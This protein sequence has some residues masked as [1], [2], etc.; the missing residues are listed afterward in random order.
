MKP[1]SATPIPGAAATAEDTT[2]I[3]IDRER[4]IVDV[5]GTLLTDL[6]V[7]TLKKGMSLAR[8]LIKVGMPDANQALRTTVLNGKT[9]SRELVLTPSDKWISVHIEPVAKNGRISG[10]Q[11]QVSDISAWRSNIDRRQLQEKMANLSL[12]A[13]QLA[14]RLKTPLATILNQ[15]GFLLLD[16]AKSEEGR[17]LRA[18]LQA[19][20]EQV[21]ALSV[22][23]N[24]L[25]AFAGDRGG[26]T[27][28]VRI[29]LVMEKAVDLIRMMYGHAAIR[30][31]MHWPED[32]PPVLGDEIAL[33]QCFLHLLRNSLEAMTKSGR[34]TIEGRLQ[35]ANRHYLDIIIQD[36]GEG[37]AAAD[38]NRVF[39]PFFK[40]KLGDHL[41]LGLCIAY[42]IVTNLKGYMRLD[43]KPQKGTVVTVSLPVARSIIQ[44]G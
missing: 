18:E 12:L 19:I 34:L 9:L 38:L 31:Q 28:L 27:K 25:D 10:A 32:L 22:I 6:G 43:S 3:V 37:I 40:K 13:N 4:R 17:R 26:S 44:K 36:N 33:E 42:S 29:P 24:A 21:Y 35:A 14:N 7:T 39:E 23:T 30:Y 5:Q 1:A 15:I 8:A 11:V 41:G 20:Q 16:E 2:R